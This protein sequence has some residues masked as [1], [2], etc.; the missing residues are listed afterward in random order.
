MK[1]REGYNSEQIRNKSLE[2]ILDDLGDRQRDV[3]N[4]ISK[5]QPISNE[6]IAEH[7][8]V[9]PHQVTP[10]V[11]E[12]REMGIVEFAGESVSTISKRK[13]SLW[14]VNPEGKQLSLFS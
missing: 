10:R 3:Y 5:W 9:F 14:R 4:I 1:V 7:L 8:G 2:S 12:L 6:R 11:Y 13:V